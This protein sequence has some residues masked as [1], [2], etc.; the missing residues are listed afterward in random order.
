MIKYTD[1]YVRTLARGLCEP[2][3]HFVAAGAGSH[4]SFWTFKI[5]FFKHHILVVATSERLIV[6]DHRKGLLFDR[7][8]KVESYR[9][10]DI[11]SITLKG[12]FTK[13]LVVKDSS[14]RSLLVMSLRYPTPIPNNVPQLRTVV[15]TWEQRRA[16]APQQAH[17]A[18][19]PATRGMPALA[20]QTHVTL[21]PRGAFGGS[22]V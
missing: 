15:Q 11:G 6:L 16:L 17:A 14:N 10:S 13:K 9:W 3:E 22:H 7:L 20:A 19:H 8:D 5:P 4:Q 1:L 21:D 18:L 2:G 12:A